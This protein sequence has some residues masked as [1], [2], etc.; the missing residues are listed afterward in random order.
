[1]TGGDYDATAPSNGKYSHPNQL[2]SSSDDDWRL[3]DRLSSHF[4][5]FKQ[6]PPRRKLRPS[7]KQLHLSK[8]IEMNTTKIR[9]ITVSAAIVLGFGAAAVS[10]GTSSSQYVGDGVNKYIVRFTDLD[11]SKVE[12][13]AMLY[14]R[15]R[16]AAAIVC[17]PLESR[18]LGM[19]ATQYQVCVD[20][21]IAGAVASVGSPMLSQ[22][23]GSHAKGD[24][25]AVPQ[26]ARAN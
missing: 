23:Y 12:G 21:A 26:L 14:N 11:I 1:M 5:R 16:Q 19:A 18:T 6:S 25:T 8:E 17:R 9:A 24:K 10:A 15:L 3:F 22:Y 13:A 7:N 2:V 20:H 4:R